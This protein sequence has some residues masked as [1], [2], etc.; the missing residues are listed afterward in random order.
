MQSGLGRVEDPTIVCIFG[1]SSSALE[2][3]S[4]QFAIPTLSGVGALPNIR[5]CITE[6]LN[7][8]LESQVDLR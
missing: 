5:Q 6:D 8:N 4:R 3:H 1:L 2:P 7:V